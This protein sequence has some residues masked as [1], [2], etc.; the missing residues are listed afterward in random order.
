MVA[1]AASAAHV[2]VRILREWLEDQG[3]QIWLPHFPQHL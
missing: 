3:L 2:A 1:P